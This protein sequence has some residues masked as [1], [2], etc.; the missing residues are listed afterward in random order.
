MKQT[1]LKP[2]PAPKRKAGLRQVGKRGKRNEKAIASVRRKVKE[3][4]CISCGYP[5]V[6]AAHILGKGRYPELRNHPLN[7]VPLCRLCHDYYGT[8]RDQWE[9]FIEIRYRGRLDQLRWESQVALQLAGPRYMTS[10]TR[11]EEELP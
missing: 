4:V 11:N 6:D 9:E 3:Q 1:A 7:V 2:G 8:Q 10:S 5:Y